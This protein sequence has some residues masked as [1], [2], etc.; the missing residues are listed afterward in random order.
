METGK[1]AKM[2]KT[3]ILPI[4][5][6]YNFLVKVFNRLDTLTVSINILGGQTQSILFFTIYQDYL[7]T[8]FVNTRWS[9]RLVSLVVITRIL[10]QSLSNLLGKKIKHVRNDPQSN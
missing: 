5:T 3:V 4:Y 6:D 9:N 2:M 8:D 1:N 7:D 10:S